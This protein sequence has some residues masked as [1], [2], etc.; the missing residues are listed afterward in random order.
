[1]TEAQ[2]KKQ[3]RQMLR[4]LTPGSLLHLLSEIFTESAKRAQRRGNETTQKQAQEVAATLFV[5]SIGVDAVCP[6]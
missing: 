2:T 3:L 4:S 1:M 5:V 6:R